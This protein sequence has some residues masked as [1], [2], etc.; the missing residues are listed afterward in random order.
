MKTLTALMLGIVLAGTMVGCASRHDRDYDRTGYND[1]TYRQSDST[2]PTT[3]GAMRQG[4][5]EGA[6]DAARD[7]TSPY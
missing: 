7:A 2:A 4:V 1:R 6:R 3:G 5:R